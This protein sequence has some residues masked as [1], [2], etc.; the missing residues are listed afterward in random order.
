MEPC[1]KVPSLSQ[2]LH[3]ALHSLEQIGRHGA[4]QSDQVLEHLC[5]ELMRSYLCV[6]PGAPIEK[7]IL[8]TLSTCLSSWRSRWFSLSSTASSQSSP[9]NAAKYNSGN[10]TTGHIHAEP[11]VSVTPPEHAHAADEHDAPDALH[12]PVSHV[13]HHDLS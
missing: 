1:L 12:T 7:P 13:G 8:D 3:T 9:A 10:A 6:P 4:N 11:K 5:Q 2:D